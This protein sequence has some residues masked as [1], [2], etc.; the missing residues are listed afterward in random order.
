MKKIILLVTIC[1]TMVSCNLNRQFITVQDK[2][3]TMY[4]TIYGDILTNS[5]TQQL[6]QEL[7]SLNKSCQTTR[8]IRKGAQKFIKASYDKRIYLKK[9]V[10]ITDTSYGTII[11]RSE[12][13]KLD[14]EVLMLLVLSGALFLFI[15]LRR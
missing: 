4:M 7:I 11:S 1:F 12:N 13:H 10:K 3:V 9:V 2:N 8:E 14:I 5:E 15:I 6:Q